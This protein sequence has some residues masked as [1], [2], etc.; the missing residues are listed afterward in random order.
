VGELPI[1]SGGSIAFKQRVSGEIA[2]FMQRWDWI[3]SPLI[4]AVALEVVVRPNPK[5]PAAVLHDLDNIVRDYLIP[6]I[7]PAF[8]TVSDQRWTIDFDE[9][10]ER[11]P[12]LAASWGPNPTP[13]VGTRN[14]VTRYEAWR[15]PAVDGEA[16]FAS[17]AL[18]ADIDAKGDLMD[19]MD[20]HISKWSDQL[21]VDSRR[22]WRRRRRY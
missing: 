6:G 9:L 15:L 4:I 13:P 12:D 3:I 5:T 16:G 17:V 20:E 21:S 2:A 1:A 18:V 22:S 10:R 8:G 19:R 11:D 7:V 14:G